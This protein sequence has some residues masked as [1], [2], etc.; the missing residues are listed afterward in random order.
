MNIRLKNSL[1]AMSLCLISSAVFASSTSTARSSSWFASQPRTTPGG[2]FSAAPST[3]LPQT[4]TLSPA[5]NW[6]WFR[7]PSFSWSTPS[8][9]TTTNLLVASLMAGAAGGG[10]FGW[11]YWQRQKQE[12]IAREQEE[13]RQEGFR[14]SHE[15][16]AGWKRAEREKQ[17]REG[18]LQEA[19]DK[20]NN[21]E[22]EQN[23]AHQEWLRRTALTPQQR[24]AEDDSRRLQQLKKRAGTKDLEKIDRLKLK[25]QKPPAY[26]AQQQPPP[27]SAE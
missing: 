16:Q 22:R 5:S 26:S 14:L 19:K 15:Q 7:L 3:F 9:E 20:K 10:Y 11:R 6:S 21:I 18:A 12:R 17:E 25:L 1:L 4:A 24:E 2:S 27:Y 8:R 23:A 13:A